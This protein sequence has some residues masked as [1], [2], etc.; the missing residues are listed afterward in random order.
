MHVDFWE[1]AEEA[2][3]HYSI[4]LPSTK[5][6]H[7]I[8]HE[9]AMNEG[10]RPPQPT[11]WTG[12]ENIFAEKFFVFVD[13]FSRLVLLFEYFLFAIFFGMYSIFPFI[14]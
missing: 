10:L 3:F 1:G 6:H 14:G 8:K 12:N 9:P 13:G 2:R 4:H 5:P 11:F 7:S